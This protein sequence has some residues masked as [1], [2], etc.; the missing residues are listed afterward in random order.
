MRTKGERFKV[1]QYV[2]ALEIGQCLVVTERAQAKMV[3]TEISRRGY[4]SKFEVSGKAFKVWK[5]DREREEES[6]D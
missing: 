1:R 4:R 2:T 6:I 3:A 5:L